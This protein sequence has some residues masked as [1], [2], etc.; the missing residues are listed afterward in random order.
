MAEAIVV[1]KHR[2][3]SEPHSLFENPLKHWIPVSVQNAGDVERG[4]PRS[5]WL[6]HE[7]CLLHL[8]G[9]RSDLLLFRYPIESDFEF[10]CETQNGGSMATDGGLVYGGIQFQQDASQDTLRISNADGDSITKVASPFARHQVEPVFNRVGIR[11]HE[12]RVAFESN[13]HPV[14][15]DSMTPSSPWL[16]LQSS[17]ANRPVFRNL[18]LKGE[19]KIPTSI[20]LISDKLPRLGDKYAR[21]SPRKVRRPENGASKMACCWA[22]LPRLSMAR[23]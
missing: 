15:N 1:Q 3:T 12:S 4:S 5:V 14:W 9:G 8:T 21:S 11:S 7:Q 6:F 23:A 10:V 22:E 16:G 19:I 13:S 2:G 20:N 18:Q 17:G